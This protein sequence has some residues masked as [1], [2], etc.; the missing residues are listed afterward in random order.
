LRRHRARISNVAAGAIGVVLVVAVCWVVFGGPIPFSG[1]GFKLEAVYT[2]QTELH[3][4]SP[5]RI[6][7]V[8]VGEVTGIQHIGGNS[9]ATLV[10][11]SIAR[12]GLPIHADATTNIRPRLFL[13]GNY[14]INLQPGT[15][16]APPLSS[17]ATL[18]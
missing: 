10:T 11:M 13:E 4:A 2:S 9:P 7:G 17:G 1:G 6:A 3:L 15:P 16:Q 5:V 8:D 12:K 18:S 14:Y